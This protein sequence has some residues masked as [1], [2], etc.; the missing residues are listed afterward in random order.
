MS[1]PRCDSAALG[2][3]RFWICDLTGR[4]FTRETVEP[5]D[6]QTVPRLCH[7][8]LLGSGSSVTIGAMGVWVR[9]VGSGVKRRL[10]PVV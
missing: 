8:T 6:R 9:T 7:L 4:D 10:A 3:A 5:S 1:D 2:E